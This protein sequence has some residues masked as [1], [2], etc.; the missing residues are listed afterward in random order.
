[1]NDDDGRGPYSAIYFFPPLVARAAFKVGRLSAPLVGCL[2]RARFARTVS[3]WSPLGSDDVDS[4][5]GVRGQ[6]D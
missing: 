6:Q 5:N 1:M 4:A 2:L 3:I